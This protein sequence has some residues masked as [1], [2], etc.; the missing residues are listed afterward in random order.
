VL[1]RDVTASTRFLQYTDGIKIL[2]SEYNSVKL[3]PCT[4]LR[5]IP[6]IVPFF[7]KFPR[8]HLLVLP[9]RAVIMHNN[10]CP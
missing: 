7:F 8:L 4:I 10:T 6:N 2:T 1:L 5:V 3:L 9:I